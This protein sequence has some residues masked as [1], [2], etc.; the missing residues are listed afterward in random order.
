MTQPGRRQHPPPRRVQRPLDELPILHLEA[1]I[2]SPTAW[3]VVVEGQVETR[4]VYSLDEI[5]DMPTE[6]RVWDMH[7]VWGWTRPDCHW[8][9]VPVSRLLDAARPLAQAAYAVARAVEG[10]Y[11]SCL[12]LQE[13]RE[14]LLAWRLDGRELVPEHGGPLRL[15]LP[16]RKWAYKNVKWIGGFR[17]T[18]QF[19]PGFWEELVGNPHGDVPPEIQDLRFE[20]T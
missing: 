16:P 20:T 14:G 18:D 2:P 17:V 1:E 19:S 13:A 5:R 11:A 8:E 9:G 10:R 3:T 6:S 7:C 4:G 12:V 15:V